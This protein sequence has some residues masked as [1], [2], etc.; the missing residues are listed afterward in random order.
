VDL[1]NRRRVQRALEVCVQTGRPFSAFEHEMRWT[2]PPIGVWVSWP[3]AE[4]RE[5]I[6]ERARGMVARGVVAEVER[7][8]GRC[9]AT[10]RQALG[11][12]LVQAHLRGEMGVEEMQGRLVQAT[13]QYAK[14]QE[15]WF[16]R[17]TALLAVEAAAAVEAALGLVRD[18]G[19]T[20]REI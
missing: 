11:L 7:E 6:A 3:R 8:G 15:T 5:R 16:R 17:E 1:K 12:G 9:G 2:G 18:R 13:C 14:R 20:F 10:A 4:L 19:L